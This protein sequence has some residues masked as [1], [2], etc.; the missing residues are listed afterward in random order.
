MKAKQ[1]QFL[2]LGLGKFGESVAQNL[3]EMGRDVLAVDSDPEI[4]EAISGHVTQA[5]Q[6]DVTDEAALIALGARNFDVAVVS[7]GDVRSSIL[8]V[9]LL[10]EQGVKT[11][12]AKALD[13][14]HAKVL[15]RVG[16]D[17]V[18]FPERE[19]GL[20][21]AKSLVSPNVMD[22]MQLSHDHQIVEVT[23]PEKWADHTIGSL[24]VRKRYGLN[25]L[26][27]HRGDDFTVSPAADTALRLGDTLLVLGQIKDIEAL[28]E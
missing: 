8:V 10:K 16:A 12:V 1:M 22:L 14:L 20:R 18:V 11:V 3:F 26:A 24:D 21:V 9:V 25:I 28:T 4:I 5:V 17:R 2:V 19:T 7:T 13:E 6:A 23:L 27:V 15:K